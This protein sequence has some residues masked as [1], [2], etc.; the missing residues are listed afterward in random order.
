MYETTTPYLQ[1]E[2]DYRQERIRAGVARRHAKARRRRTLVRR[3]N[4]ATTR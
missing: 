2:I 4:P 3:D 1:S